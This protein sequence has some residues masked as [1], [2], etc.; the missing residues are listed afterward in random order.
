MK[1]VKDFTQ[2]NESNGDTPAMGLDI[3]GEISKLKNG[4]KGGSIDL[5]I[6]S[7]VSDTDVK[8]IKQTYK[9][10]ILKVVDDH[11]ILTLK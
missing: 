11:Y 6:V 5:G 2:Y 3:K 8:N 7:Q 9:D 1:H 10:A 4:P